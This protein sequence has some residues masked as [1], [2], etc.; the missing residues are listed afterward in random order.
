ML[1]SIFAVKYLLSNLIN[2]SAMLAV[3]ILIGATVYVLSI[4]LIAPK[5]FWQV[6]NI[7]R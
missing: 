7:A 6:V 3:T 4:F 1:G 2:T 5:L